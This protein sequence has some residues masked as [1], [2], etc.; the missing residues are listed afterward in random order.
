MRKLSVLVLI[1]LL[2]S[3]L[4]SSERSPE[5]R[6]LRNEFIREN[7]RCAVCDSE[8]DVQAHHV[9]MYKFWPNL[10]LDKTNLVTL[11][12]SKR[13]GFNCHQ[14][15]GHGGSFKYYNPFVKEDIASVRSILANCSKDRCQDE[16]EEYLK[17]VRKETR[18]FNACMA[19]NREKTPDEAEA[20]C[21]SEK[22][23]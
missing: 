12:T 10:E 15:I 3:V 17:F 16:V 18:A 22:Q 21:R 5:W 9:K 6:E 20:I 7:P 13:L 11:C 8:S 2:S 1:C 23:L 4:S 14:M 19:R